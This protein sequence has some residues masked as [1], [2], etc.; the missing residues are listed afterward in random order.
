[1]NLNLEY[2]VKIG[3]S[4][5]TIYYTFDIKTKMIRGVRVTGNVELHQVR[6][7]M[8]N[9][10]TSEND[11]VKNFQKRVGKKV[12]IK[13]L[14]LDISFD[15]FWEKY[16]NKVGKKK[17]TEHLWS[18]LNTE[19]RQKAMVYMEEYNSHLRRN[20][21]LTKLYPETY[22]FQERWNN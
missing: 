5:A 13:F 8:T 20:P 6:W 21:T 17:R 18:L 14:P 3:E 15:D 22:L 19:D 4:P 9:A 1:M 2:M 16:G 10:P 12:M 7:V 11:L